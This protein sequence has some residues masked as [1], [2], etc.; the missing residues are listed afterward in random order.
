MQID[1]KLV[2]CKTVEEKRPEK[3]S[4]NARN[5]TLFRIVLNLFLISEILSNK[6]K[7]VVRTLVCDATIN[8]Q[9]R[10]PLSGLSRQSIT[11]HMWTNI[12]VA[13]DAPKKL[14]NASPEHIHLLKFN[15]N[16][17]PDAKLWQMTKCIEDKSD[18]DEKSRR[19][20]LPFDGAIR[21][22]LEKISRQFLVRDIKY[23]IWRLISIWCK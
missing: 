20:V 7:T 11:R 2:G 21:W 22:W 8:P 10:G 13:N 14:R 1:L 17:L 19:N 15:L 4:L 23:N 3:N 12:L 5:I 6:N 9:W 16:E 18:A